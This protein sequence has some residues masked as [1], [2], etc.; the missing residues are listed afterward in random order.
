MMSQL[1][2][3]HNMGNGLGISHSQQYPQQSM[4]G[5]LPMSDS[6]NGTMQYNGFDMPPQQPQQDMFDSPQELNRRTLTQE[7][8]DAMNRSGG[9]I[10][11]SDNYAQYETGLAGNDDFLSDCFPEL[12]GQNGKQPH[13]YMYQGN[14][15]LPLSSHD[16]SVPSTVS[17]LSGSQFPSHGSMQGQ[18]N[19]SRA[20]S[21]WDGSRS[22]SVH[23][24]EPFLLPMPASSHKPSATS[25]QWQPGQSVPVDP[26]ALSEEF[27]QVAKA[28]QSAQQQTQQPLQQQMHEQ[29]LAWP[30][31]EAFTHRDSSTSTS[32]A[33]SMSQFGIHTPQPVQPA[34]F[35]SPAPPAN[36]AARRQRPRPAG[37]HLGA[38]RSQSYSG[39]VQPASPGQ[40]Q[41]QT[42]TPGQPLRRIRSS[43]VINGVSQ[44]RV[45]KLPGASQ[46]SPL[47]WSFADALNSPKAMRHASGQSGTGSLAPPTPMSP[48]EFPRTQAQ[49]FQPQG[50][51]S[52]QPSISETDFEHNVPFAPSASV[53]VQNSS[54]PPHTP[55]YH[56][57]NF[58]QQRV[59]NNVITENTPPQSAPASQQCFPTNTFT[60]QPQP[61][62][63][64]VASQPPAQAPQQ[65]PQPFVPPPQ[66]QFMNVIVPEQQFQNSSTSF[67]PNQQFTAPAMNSSAGMVTQY[68]HGVPIVNE[69]GELQMLFAHQIPFMQ[70]HAQPPPPRHMPAQQQVSNPQGGFYGMFSAAMPQPPMQVTASVPKQPATAPAAELFVHEY[71][72]PHDLKRSATPRKT[73][74]DSGPKNYTFT[75]QTPEHFEKHKKAAEA[76]ATA[77][78][79][80]A[81]S[82]GAAA[83]SS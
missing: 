40:L 13:A 59:G 42:L 70:Q 25:S 33:Q 23:Q 43:N 26:Y 21:E 71:S 55:M 45:Q 44:G 54:S 75:N 37:L 3:E 38:P 12:Q 36:I 61:Q 64:P 1:A 81:S 17:D 51:A 35:K 39:A 57:Q 68:P 6:S 74:A 34:T 4:Y 22:S 65:Q 52:R 83:H 20:S 2:P 27:K 10:S 24:E 69:A 80:P 56:Q 16:S 15:P 60:T 63:Q 7:Q 28:R 41:P 47:A 9:M 18:S 82:G 49:L 29:P 73:M 48:R 78:S 62:Y 31:D 72:P 5:G 66:H 14:I 46:R 77:N 67:E 79:S 30:G 53:P 58:V 32:L 76:K 50:P 11:T 19:D 8:F